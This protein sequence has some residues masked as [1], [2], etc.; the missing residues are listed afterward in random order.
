[1]YYKLTKEFGRVKCYQNILHN[2][3]KQSEVVQCIHSRR[4]VVGNGG[5][6]LLCISI[7][8]EQFNL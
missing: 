2:F 4:L 6:N 3:L 5:T 8:I 7:E 1:M